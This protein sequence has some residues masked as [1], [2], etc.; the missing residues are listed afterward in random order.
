[1][2]AEG[3]QQW[4]ATVSRESGDFGQAW[5]AEGYTEYELGDGWGLNAKVETEF[6]IDTTYHDR[7]QYRIGLQK[8]F[9]LS[10]PASFALQASLLGGEAMEGPERRGE[11]YETHAAIRTSFSMFGQEGYVTL[12]APAVSAATA[13]TAGSPRSRPGWNSFPAGTSR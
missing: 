8:A 1:M 5:R 10:E 12:R 7:S 2:P 3:V 9:A 11:G 6:G 4:F 13:A